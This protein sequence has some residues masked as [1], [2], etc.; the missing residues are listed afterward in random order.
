LYLP[1]RTEFGFI[2]TCNLA[3]E[4]FLNKN[5]LKFEDLIHE[6]FLHDLE[7]IVQMVSATNIDLGTIV[8]P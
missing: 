3:E 8:A 7:H 6:S 1:F 4:A 5:F 2:E